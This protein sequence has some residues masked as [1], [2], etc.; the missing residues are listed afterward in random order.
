MTHKRTNTQ[1]DDDRG[2]NNKHSVFVWSA[3]FSSNWMQ[4]ATSTVVANRRRH[5]IHSICARYCSTFGCECCGTCA[6]VARFNRY[7]W[8]APH[9]HLTNCEW[10][11]VRKLLQLIGIANVIMFNISRGIACNGL[12]HPY[13][14]RSIKY[15]LIAVWLRW[16][17]TLHTRTHTHNTHRNIADRSN[18]LDLQ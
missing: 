5:T 16:W 11:P 4:L 2:I 17:H 14:S 1:S 8:N 10:N 3:R 15:E 6:P 12:V 13:W 18:Q 7:Y 9:S